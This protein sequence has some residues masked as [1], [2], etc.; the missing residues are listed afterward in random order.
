MWPRPLVRGVTAGAVGTL[1][2]EAATYLD[3]AVRGRPASDLPERSVERIAGLVGVPIGGGDDEGEE[4]GGDGAGR[5]P[6]VEGAGALVGMAVGCGVGAAYGMLR[7]RLGA[8]LRPWVAGL[9]IAAAA[10]AAT[11]LPNALLG[12]SDPR[13]WSIADWAEDVVPHLCYGLATAATLEVLR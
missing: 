2:L 12:V 5:G 8:D 7:T 10:T 1:A 9:G 3:M 13:E 4:D 6:R 11:A